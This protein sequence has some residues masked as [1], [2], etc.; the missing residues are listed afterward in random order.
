MPTRSQKFIPPK[1]WRAFWTGTDA[2]GYWDAEPE[3]G[4]E[5]PLRY[6]SA[7]TDKDPKLDAWKR[8][9]HRI[10][11]PPELGELEKRLQ[12]GFFDMD[13]D[14]FDHIAMKKTA[15]PHRIV[16]LDGSGIGGQGSGWFSSELPEA[17][18]E[19]PL[20]IKKKPVVKKAALK[21]KK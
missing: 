13:L 11:N 5:K 3:D 10:K 14:A 17:K 8:L 15:R 4:S 1:G 9:I 6:P 2:A 12:G 18:E 16:R 21:K 7:G 19:K 20:V